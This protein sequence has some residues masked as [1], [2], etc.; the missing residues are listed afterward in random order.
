MTDR[1]M[2]LFAEAARLLADW[3]AGKPYRKTVLLP[4]PMRPR[5]GEEA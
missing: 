2:T 1:S 5:G 3:I 4:H